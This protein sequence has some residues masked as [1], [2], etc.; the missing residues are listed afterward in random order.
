MSKERLPHSPNKQIGTTNTRGQEYRSFTYLERSLIS[1]L[2]TQNEST[3]ADCR[4]SVDWLLCWLALCAQSLVH[5]TRQMEMET[6]LLWHNK[7]HAVDMSWK[8]SLSI[9]TKE[10]TSCW[11]GSWLVFRPCFDCLQ[12]SNHRDKDQSLTDHF[13]HSEI[14]TKCLSWRRLSLSSAA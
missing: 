3:N 10:C 8:L 6:I 9:M 2:L 11:V 4:S 14:L 7:V 1:I 12:G 13:G 5:Q